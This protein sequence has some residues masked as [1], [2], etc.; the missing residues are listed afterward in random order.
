[1]KGAV[2]TPRPRLRWRRLQE[3]LRRP[4][5][6]PLTR[7]QFAAVQARIWARLAQKLD[8]WPAD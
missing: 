3:L 1:M 2:T 4:P 7:Q 8:A 6:L 5:P